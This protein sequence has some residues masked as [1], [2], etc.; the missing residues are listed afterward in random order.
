M[1]SESPKLKVVLTQSAKRDLFQIWF[2]NA[3]HWHPTWA[4]DFEAFLLREIHELG[5]NPSAGKPVSASPDCRYVLI[6]K[7]ASGHGHYV[8]YEV[9]GGVVQ[10]L[11]VLHDSRDWQNLFLEGS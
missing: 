3:E 10:V 9:I 6:R 5:G 2:W 8:I 4:D 7:T 1:A 11:R